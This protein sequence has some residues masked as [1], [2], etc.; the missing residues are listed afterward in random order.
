MKL[1]LSTLVLASFVAA[2][3]RGNK[4]A[5]K[6]PN[7]C[8]GKQNQLKNMADE[9]GI[10]WK[11]KSRQRKNKG[12]S[13]KCKGKCP[14]GFFSTAPRKVRCDEGIGWMTKKQG[15]ATVAAITGTCCETVVATAT[16]DFGDSGTAHGAGATGHGSL[17]GVITLTEYSGCADEQSRTTITGRLTVPEANKADTDHFA[18]GFHGFHV[19]AGGLADFTTPACTDLG[20]HFKFDVDGQTPDHGNPLIDQPPARHQGDLGNFLVSDKHIIDVFYT[21][22]TVNINLGGDTDNPNADISEKSL[23]FHADIDTL[24]NHT[25]DKGNAGARTACCIIQKN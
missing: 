23:V 25:D 1:S 16:C 17:S 24:E 15:P 13:K 2:D 22:S 5:D 19:H 8:A 6:G 14:Q 11:C 20:G 18:T 12:D 9:G 10:K 4:N 21:D 7:W 3:E